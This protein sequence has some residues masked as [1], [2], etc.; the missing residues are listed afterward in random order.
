MITG[1][2]VN[3]DLFDIQVSTTSATIPTSIYKK[4]E[5]ASVLKKAVKL[6]NFNFGGRRFTT[7]VPL[8][9]KST[10]IE[11]YYFYLISPIS[12]GLYL[13]TI[14]EDSISATAIS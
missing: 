10:V 3:V 4:I 1:G 11:A 8:L 12:N 2:F 5:H 13:V 6:I 14:T 9:T 7:H